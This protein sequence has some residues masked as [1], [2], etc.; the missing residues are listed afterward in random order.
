MGLEDASGDCAE[1][2]G[3]VGE[4]G[5]PEDFWGGRESVEQNPGW[6]ALAG[7][8]DRSGLAPGIGFCPW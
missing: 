4:A 8:G 6:E 2:Q 1:M 7:A 3:W 5:E